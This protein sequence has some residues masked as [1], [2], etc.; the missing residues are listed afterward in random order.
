[1]TD[2]EFETRVL[3]ARRANLALYLDEPSQD[4][5][6]L[7]VLFEETV[8]HLRDYRDRGESYGLSPEEL[9]EDD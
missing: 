6:R 5:A 2:E 4:A 3:A 7:L 1:M 8:Q 9:G